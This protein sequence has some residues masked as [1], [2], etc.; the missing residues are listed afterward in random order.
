MY[1]DVCSFDWSGKRNTREQVLP[2]ADGAMSKL[3]IDE[4]V[5]VTSPLK[6]VPWAW[7]GE[8]LSIGTMRCGY[9][10]APERDAGQVFGAGF[11]TTGTGQLTW[12]SSDLR[13]D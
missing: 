2:E 9:S 13:F 6:D 1:D 8:E 3:K 4:T 7:S 11:G 10:K 5:V 12:H